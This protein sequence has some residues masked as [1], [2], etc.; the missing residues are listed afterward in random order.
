[1][2]LVILK[3][4]ERFSKAAWYFQEELDQLA[5]QV[6]LAQRVQRALAVLMAQLARLALRALLVQR[7]LPVQQAQRVRLGLREQV[8]AEELRQL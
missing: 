8:E 3:F 2:S 6:L 7:G 1:M 4:Q 5:P